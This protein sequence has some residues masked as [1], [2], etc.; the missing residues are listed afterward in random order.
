[1]EKFTLYLDFSYNYIYVEERY[2]RINIANL[3]IY[4]IL[5]A[6]VQIFI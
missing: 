5:D 3:S 2:F 6:R 1:M 4:N